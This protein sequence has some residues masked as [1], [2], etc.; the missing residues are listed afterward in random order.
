M[1]GEPTTTFSDP[2]AGIVGHERVRGALS[3][4]VASGR[5]HHAW[6][7]AGRDGIGKRLVAQRFAQLLMCAHSEPG[8]G[9]AQ[10]AACGECRHCR[11]LAAEQHPDG[12]VL[13]PEGRTIKIDQVRLL[14]QKLSFRPFEARVRVVLVERADA[15]GDAS[16]NAMLKTLEE[17]GEGNVF[18]LLT[19]QPQALLSTIVSRCQPVRF[20]PFA[21][22]ALARQL[23]ARGVAPDK[24]SLIGVLAEGSYGRALELAEEDLD[25]Q[26]SVLDTLMTLR[27]RG[28]GVADPGPVLELADAIAR[29]KEH[30]PSVLTMLRAWYRDVLLLRSGAAPERISMRW[31]LEQLQAQAAASPA[32]SIEAALEALTDITLAL[33][34]NVNP[35]LAVERLL[36]RLLET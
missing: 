10:L 30:L 26:L 17:P 32:E 15:L 12:L 19:D 33:K 8:R 13:R 3:Q 24:A 20:A 27:E 4:A 25:D 36:F 1:S 34:G 22:D 29:D 2:F 11:R 18:V 21:P 23:E 31:R 7:F 14:Q 28:A 35:T 9:L 5:V 16:A 6:L